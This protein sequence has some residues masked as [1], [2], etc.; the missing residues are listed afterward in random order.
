MLDQDSDTL[1][2]SCPQ[3]PEPFQHV[4]SVQ[5]VGKNNICQAMMKTDTNQMSYEDTAGKIDDSPLVGENGTDWPIIPSSIRNKRPGKVFPP[6]SNTGK[7]RA[8]DSKQFM[9]N[10]HRVL[11]N[12]AKISNEL[13]AKR[14]ASAGPNPG[15]RRYLIGSFNPCGIIGLFLRIFRQMEPL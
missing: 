1:S 12:K 7:T 8:E 10:I 9:S 14:P 3:S 11:T 2:F 4:V 15:S 5:E 13:F 6:G